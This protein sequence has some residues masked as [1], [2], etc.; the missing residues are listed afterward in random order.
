MERERELVG[1]AL[2][3]AHLREIKAKL[4]AVGAKWR[5]QSGREDRKKTREFYQDA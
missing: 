3:K 5:D 1:E 4:R 2:R